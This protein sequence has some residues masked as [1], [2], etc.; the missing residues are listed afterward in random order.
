MLDHV[1]RRVIAAAA[2]VAAACAGPELRP[3]TEATPA[4]LRA[5]AAVAEDA[6]VQVAASTRAWEGRPV[7]LETELTPVLVDILNQSSRPLRIGYEGFHFISE[8][9]T[10]YAALPPYRIEAEVARPVAAGRPYYPYAGFG[11]APYLRVY[12]PRLDIYD[13]PF[14]FSDR[15]Y[16]ANAPIWS[17]Y[18][19]GELPTQ[20]ML[21]R[22]LP[23]GVVEPGGRVGGFLYFQRL[24][25]PGPFTLSV[26]LVDA[27]TGERF[28]AITIPFVAE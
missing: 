1:P 16:G 27:K 19:S 25:G 26:D 2:L 24:E 9:E 23:E 13:G 22:A 4:Q 21:Q 28:G 11:G 12:Y 5:E 15:Y 3:S 14:A 20:D 8:A 7:T 6:G 10:S 18:R 17:R